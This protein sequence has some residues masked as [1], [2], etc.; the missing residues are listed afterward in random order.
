MR[1]M[2]TASLAKYKPRDGKIRTTI[3]DKYEH[4]G[5]KKKLTFHGELTPETRDY[6][7]NRYVVLRNFIPKELI[8]VT[9]DSWKTIESK[10]DVWKQYFETEE[11]CIPDNVKTS[12]NT[13][14]GGY[15]FPPAVGLHHWMRRELQKILNFKIRETY[16]YSR[17]Y[18][19]GA[20]LRSHTDRFS[21]EVSATICLDYRSDDGKPW[22]IWVDPKNYLDTT[23]DKEHVMDNTQNLNHRERLKRG[24]VKVLLEPGDVLLYQGPNIPHWRDQFIG[25]YS[26][27]MF[28]HF[29]NLSGKMKD[30]PDN[31]YE[32][33]K[34]PTGNGYNF[35]IN[36][37]GRKHRYDTDE[38]YY[39][40]MG[41][42]W[43]NMTDN[44]KSYYVNNFTEFNIED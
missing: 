28:L 1:M 41:E 32:E 19:R 16:S 17:K 29:W 8:D 38:Q 22:S 27:H 40:K 14:E 31:A 11:W 12:R 13:S 36:F 6:I 7:K 37:D 33:K 23:T 2:M 43:D 21:C 25:D 34:I 42:H 15:Q 44:Q 39:G 20:Y 4:D 3:V 9:L 18:I 5:Q 10:H 24:C 35:H 30:F 26:Y